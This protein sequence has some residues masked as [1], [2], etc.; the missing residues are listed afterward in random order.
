VDTLAGRQ[1]PIRHIPHHPGETGGGAGQLAPLRQISE[2]DVE[3]VAESAAGWRVRRL[4]HQAHRPKTANVHADPRHQPPPATSR[5]VGLVEVCGGELIWK[6][7]MRGT[8]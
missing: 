5:L 6:L 8:G 4:P 2:A 1:T 3:A 7:Q